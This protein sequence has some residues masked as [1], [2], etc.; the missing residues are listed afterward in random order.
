MPRF[1]E[2]H[3]A[4]TSAIEQL[5]RW[6][7]G[8]CPDVKGLQPEF[9]EFVARRIV[10]AA[11]TIGA[12]TTA[13]GQKCTVNI[14]VVFTSTPQALVDHIQ[15]HY[16]WLLGS[17][18]RPGDTQFSRAV[19][20]WYTTATRAIEPRQEP[21]RGV[22]GPPPKDAPIFT[23]AAEF[24]ATVTATPGVIPDPPY[25]AGAPSGRAGSLLTVG[26]RSELFHVLVIV[27]AQK[28][29]GVALQSVADYVSLVALTR[30]SALDTCNELPSILDLLSKSCSERPRPLAL[31]PADTAF[32]K[33]LY[34]SE[35]D[36]K[37]N[38]EQGEVRQRMITILRKTP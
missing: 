26:L 29:Q 15:R 38:I 31:T 35:L 22:N 25:G 11:Q 6:R 32:L 8:V 19:Q 4:P 21:I 24:A 28:V 27:D 14:E 3:S 10:S 34:S 18:R 13:A 12:V 20:S 23:G 33:A 17:A 1:V 30:I 9:N 7:A 36:Q 2:S 5:P 37:L 16:S